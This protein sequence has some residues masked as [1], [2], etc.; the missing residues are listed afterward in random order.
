MDLTS[1]VKSQFHVNMNTDFSVC[2]PQTHDPVK[3]QS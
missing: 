1:V 3:F 2:G